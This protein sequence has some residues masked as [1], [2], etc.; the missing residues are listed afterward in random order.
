MRLRMA[1]ESRP[2]RLRRAPKIL[3]VPAVPNGSSAE[4]GSSTSAESKSRQFN[5]LV[6][7]LGYEAWR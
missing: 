5:T 1:E 4:A 3:A 2:K 7:L 6:V